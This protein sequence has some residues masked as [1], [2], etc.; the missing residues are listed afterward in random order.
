MDESSFTLSA[1]KRTILKDPNAHLDYT[2]RFTAWLAAASTVPDTIATAVT[3]N[4][5]GVTVN[6][7]TFVG[8]YVVLWV[9]G[10]AVGEPAS[11]TV[12]VTTAGG[13]ID[14]RTVYFKIKER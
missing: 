12:R 10:G 2:L 4:V 8:P 7:I 5:V 14:D 9:S 1:G 6:G 11:V 13:R 3:T